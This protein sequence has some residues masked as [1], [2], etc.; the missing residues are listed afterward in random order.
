MYSARKKVINPHAHK[1]NFS[2]EISVEGNGGGR[3]VKI[4]PLEAAKIIKNQMT[5]ATF[6]GPFSA[7]SKQASKV[8]QSLS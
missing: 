5:F 7:V 6:E 3:S 8:E 1:L 2:W 4:K